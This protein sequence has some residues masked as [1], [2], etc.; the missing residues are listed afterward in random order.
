MTFPLAINHNRSSI[1]R[2]RSRISSQLCR[3]SRGFKMPVLLAQV[4]L[5]RYLTVALLAF[6]FS[7]T[8]AVLIFKEK[9]SALKIAAIVLAVASIITIAHLLQFVDIRED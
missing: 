9:L 1:S 2:M 3:F 7:T 4:I 8:G 5:H 6:V